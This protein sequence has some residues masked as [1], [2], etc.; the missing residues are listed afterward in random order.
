MK[1]P[2]L[3]E[4]QSA[5]ICTACPLPVCVGTRHLACPLRIEMARAA[6]ALATASR[7]AAAAARKAKRAELK[8]NSKQRREEVQ[9]ICLLRRERRGYWPEIHGRV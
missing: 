7:S 3:S 4:A 9:R 2:I 5:A 1:L 6:F 8:A